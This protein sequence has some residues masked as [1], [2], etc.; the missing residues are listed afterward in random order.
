MEK[1][2]SG[3]PEW[4]LT[5]KIGEGSF[6]KV[7]KARRIEGSRQFYSAIKIITISADS[8]EMGEVGMDRRDENSVR[9]YLKGI[10]DDCIGEIEMMD[11]LKGNSNIVAVEDFK[12]AEHANDPGW[13][14]YI[15]MELLESFVNYSRR[16]E[17]TE[18]DVIRLGIDICNA[19]E[20]CERQKIIHRDIKPANIFVAPSGSFKLGDFGIARKLERANSTM[21]HKGTYSYMAPEI[22][23]GQ[24]HYDATIDTYSLGLVLYLL[25]NRNRAPFLDPDKPDVTYLEKDEA[26]RRR[27]DGEQLP[28]PSQASPA[29]A[30]VI[31]RACSYRPA[32]RYP[33]ASAMKADLLKI[34]NGESFTVDPDA[35]TTWGNQGDW[36][37]TQTWTSAAAQEKQQ[38]NGFPQQEPQKKERKAPM[39]LLAVLGAA[40]IVAAGFL[41]AQIFFGSDT[42]SKEEVKTEAAKDQSEE[43]TPKETVTE[44]AAASPQ[45]TPTSTP[46]AVPQPTATAVPEQAP[47]QAPQETSPS[48]ETYYVVNCQESITLRT[49]PSTSAGEICQIPL[50]AAVSYVGGAENGFYEI[51]YDGSR[52]YGLASYLSKTPQSRARSSAASAASY[53]TYYVVNC[54]ESITLRT[55]PSTSAGEICQIPLGAAVSYVGGAENGFYEVI[56]DGS[57][58]YALASYLSPNGP[59]NTVGNA[60]GTCVVVNCQES[61]TLRTSPSTSAAEICQIPLGATVSYSGV[62][63]NGFYLVVYDGNTGYALKEYLQMQ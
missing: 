40:A 1:Q 27:M 60:V 6:G 33:S 50:G 47:A 4:E 45:A 59:W 49:S 34:Q 57:R 35:T 61:I 53:E 22:F 23:Y 12:L 36:D 14:I 32:Q 42:E 16:K 31:L 19:L 37:R 28:A 58:G 21:S 26:V 25:L 18:K 46:T 63:E 51:I 15:R 10:A 3:W 2:Y 8:A 7:Y 56:Y 11:C 30:Q 29:M 55:S 5:E 13:D 48:Y 41:C 20:L 39:G 24:K 9:T 43:E 62:E 17:I 54:Q 52:G 38:K 44:E